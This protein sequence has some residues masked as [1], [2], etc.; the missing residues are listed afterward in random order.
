[1]ENET[2]M[3]G[4]SEL[5]PFARSSK[6]D[7]SNKKSWIKID[8]R[9]KLAE[10]RETNEPTAVHFQRNTAKLISNECTR[11]TSMQIVRLICAGEICGYY[12]NLKPGDGFPP[13]WLSHC[14]CRGAD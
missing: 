4:Q 1:M 13:W 8:I 7:A 14:Q 10:E 3:F 2:K 12:D 9:N 6:I 5:V 11:R